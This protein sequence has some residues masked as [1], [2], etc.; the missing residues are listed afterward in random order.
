MEFEEGEISQN[1]K[2]GFS[3]M[4]EIITPNK[5]RALIKTVG[6]KV[7][8]KYISVLFSDDEIEAILDQAAAMWTSSGRRTGKGN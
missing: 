1:S 8:L 6:K 4:E 2:D 5:A 3:N 7:L